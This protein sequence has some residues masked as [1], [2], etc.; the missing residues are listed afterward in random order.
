MYKK[1]LNASTDSTGSYDS[2]LIILP[3]YSYDEK[4]MHT[5]LTLNL[6]SNDGSESNNDVLQR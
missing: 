6:T 1:F 4:T 3:Q 2:Q 5:V